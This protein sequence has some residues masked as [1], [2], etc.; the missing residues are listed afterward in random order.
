METTPLYL[1]IIIVF[2]GYVLNILEKMIDVKTNKKKFY[3]KLWWE[4][5]KLNTLYSVG[6]IILLLLIYPEITNLIT[7]SGSDVLG[8][9]VMYALIG[10]A[11]LKIFQRVL[12]RADLDEKKKELYIY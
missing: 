8:E 3:F 7:V 2:V 4:T 12:K 1:G 10:Y 5:N 9:R 6:V 11:P